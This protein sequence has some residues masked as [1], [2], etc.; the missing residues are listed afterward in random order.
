MGEGI[1]P[2]GVPCHCQ[3]ALPTGGEFVRLDARSRE[4]GLGWR[5]GGVGN[6]RAVRYGGYTHFNIPTTTPYTQ[7]HEHTQTRTCTHCKWPPRAASMSGVASLLSALLT[8]MPSSG[9][10]REDRMAW[11]TSWDLMGGVVDMCWVY[12]TGMY[13]R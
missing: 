11:S 9:R 10:G 12:G 13:G 8:S 6:E 1:L 3:R 4:Q 2:C 5:M 7:T